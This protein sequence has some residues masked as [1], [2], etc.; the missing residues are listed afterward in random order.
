MY[1]LSKHEK[2]MLKKI[3]INA[4]IDYFRKNKYLFYYEENIENK[5][6]E[7][8]ENIDSKINQ[9]EEEK[10]LAQELEKFFTETRLFKI[11]RSLSYID[12]QILYL[13]YIE[14]MTDEQIANVLID[15]RLSINRKRRN[16]LN[17]IKDKYENV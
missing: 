15:S 10:I 9:I 1:E 11:V 14:E 17:K 7:S 13:Y 5:E 6:I 2:A 16:I 4:R 3:I 12:K 8:K